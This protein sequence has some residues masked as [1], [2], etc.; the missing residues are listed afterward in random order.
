[1]EFNLSELNPEWK[2]ESSADKTMLKRS[3]QFKSYLK[4]I[5]FVNAVAWQANLLNHHPDLEVSYQTCMVKL[6]T[7]DDKNQLSQKDFELAKA[8]DSLMS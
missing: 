7:H 6:T 4:N 3:F 5:S 1:M 8:I 2:I